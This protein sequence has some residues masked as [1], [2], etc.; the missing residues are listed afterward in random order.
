MGQSGAR[1]SAVS[2]FAVSDFVENSGLKSTASQQDSVLR[3]WFVLC[4]N[5]AILGPLAL[6]F[7][8][9]NMPSSLQ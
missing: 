7:E 6:S 2:Y 9:L 4:R 8:A 5:C 3:P 1:S